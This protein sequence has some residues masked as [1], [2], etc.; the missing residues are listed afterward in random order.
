MRVYSKRERVLVALTIPLW[1]AVVG[2]FIGV[3]VTVPD[4][5]TNVFLWLGGFGGVGATFIALRIVLT[6][7][8]T[9]RMEQDA[10]DALAGR[11]LPPDQ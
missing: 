6:G 2:L 7:R 5:R 11:P 3:V 4:A 8:S 10:F 9:R 1:L